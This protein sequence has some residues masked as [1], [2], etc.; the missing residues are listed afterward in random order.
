[1]HTYQGAGDADSSD[2]E[3]ANDGHLI[4]YDR[5]LFFVSD[6]V[7]E[8]KVYHIPINRRMDPEHLAFL[9][10]SQGLS[11]LQ[12]EF[13]VQQVMLEK[14]AINPTRISNRRTTTMDA[15]FVWDGSIDVPQVD[16]QLADRGVELRP[17]V[18][19]T[20]RDV[21]EDGEFSDGDDE[22]KG[23]INDVVRKI[24]SQFPYDIFGKG[25]N[26]RASTANSHIALQC[27]D[28][29]NITTDIFKTFDLS[30]VFTQVHAK[31]VESAFWEGILFDR[32]FPDKGTSAKPP[33]KLQKFPYMKYYM[34]WADV[35]SHLSKR[36]A[37]LIRNAMRIEFQRLY[38]LP[39]PQSD[40]LWATK[41]PS[42]A[43]WKVYPQG[44][45]ISLCPQ[46]AINLRWTKKGKIV[47]VPRAQSV[48]SDQEVASDQG[49]ASE[50]G[51]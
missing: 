31:T 27:H 30:G 8:D 45:K 40:R 3:D 11:A 6:L 20:G 23:D 29:D 13:R 44:T 24:W 28:A 19:P 7:T 5:D 48:D 32:Y 17:R 12:Q 9:Y 25:P 33:G 2:D 50:E 35:T 41:I 38:W 18:R 51:A 39:F 1:M 37:N 4:M 21:D 49:E 15:T 46:I 43:G 47:I 26:K 42:G 34:Q 10:R 22:P 16:F 14:S 36:H